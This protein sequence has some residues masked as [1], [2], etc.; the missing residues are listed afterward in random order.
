MVLRL[1][2]VQH[3]IIE[4]LINLPEGEACFEGDGEFAEW[5]TANP[6]LTDDD[7]EWED[8]GDLAGDFDYIAVYTARP[9]QTSHVESLAR[10]FL[11]GRFA[12]ECYGVKSPDAVN[13]WGQLFLISSDSTKSAHDDWTMYMDELSPLLYDGSP[14]RKTNVKGPGTKGT[15]AVEGLR[16]K[17]WMAFR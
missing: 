10:Y 11:E 1:A 13:G 2:R 3:V 7:Q 17:F 5:L 8:Y 16:C 14:I 12:G 4:T 15:R 6:E 9:R